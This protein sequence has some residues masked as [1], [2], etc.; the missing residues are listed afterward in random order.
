MC[1][2]TNLVFSIRRRGRG[3]APW[4]APSRPSSELIRSRLS[5]REIMSSSRNLTDLCR[6]CGPVVCCVVTD[7][8]E[9]ISRKNN[10]SFCELLSAFSGAAT[11]AG[12]VPFRSVSGHVTL[13]DL[14]VSFVRASEQSPR[15]LDVGERHIHAAVSH[16]PGEVDVASLIEG[17]AGRGSAPALDGPSAPWY[18]R[19][20][21]ALHASLRC[22]EYDSFDCPALLMLVAATSE[23]VGDLLA[24]FEELH[25]RRHLPTGYHNG[26]FDVSATTK[27]LVLLHDAH[28]GRVRGSE[29]P[30]AQLQRLSAT[31]RTTVCRLLSLNSISPDTPNTE[32]PDIWRDA[33]ELFPGRSRVFAGHADD[34][35]TPSLMPVF[36][37][38]KATW[39]A[40]APVHATRGCCLSPDDVLALRTFVLDVIQQG[41]VPA[42]ETRI[43]AL[44]HAVTSARK[45]VKNVIKG[46]FRR[47]KADGG[48]DAGSAQQAAH[49]LSSATTALYRHDSIEAQ[50]RLLADSAFAM[51]DYEAAL[52]MYKLVRDDYKSDRA[53]AHLGWTCAIIGV[54]LVA[55]DHQRASGGLG[56]GAAAAA[57]H[58]PPDRRALSREADSA[59]DMA[60]HA[61]AAA[62]SHTSAS[63]GDRKE[64]RPQ[65]SL[66]ARM[67]THAM[68]L[69]ADVRA[70]DVGGARHDHAA[71]TLVWAATHETALCAAVL[72]QQ[73]AFHF[74][75]AGLRRKF[76][77]HAAMAGHRFH[78]SNEELHA[79]HCY[80]AVLGLFQEQRRERGDTAP[81]DATGGWAH[82]EDHIAYTLAR[83]LYT[84]KRPEAALQFS[85]RLIASGRQSAD[86]QNTF[87]REFLFICRTQPDA[88][89]S[90]VAQLRGHRAPPSVD[91]PYD[92]GAGA[93]EQ[94]AADSEE[95]RM[96][97]VPELAL[98]RFNDTALALLAWENAAPDGAQ[99]PR[100]T[101]CTVW[102]SQEL[103][104]NAERAVTTR[105]SDG[106]PVSVS[107]RT[108]AGSLASARDDAAMPLR[109]KAAEP[110]PHWAARGEPIV[111]ELELENPLAVVIEV[112]ELQLVAEMDASQVLPAE[113]TCF[114]RPYVCLT[115]FALSGVRRQ[116]TPIHHL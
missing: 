104:L 48:D 69:A 37:A 93:L 17:S 47:P 15:P 72:H 14:H 8:V 35:T 88:I 54:C 23:P 95:Q 49:S 26:Q 109:G 58:A 86:R 87:L 9:R 77:L 57:G 34:D 89:R 110:K 29:P 102:M 18:R 20:R 79:V 11:D 51:R 65:V 39:R 6:S 75:S 103:A 24:S 19:C 108:V 78:A 112:T 116:R 105:T 92:G 84:L 67:V 98:P 107:P 96:I 38:E 2:I 113:S 7:E 25:S 13:D 106:T 43:S 101:D 10:L 3:H 73:A 71:E 5:T 4:A 52:A 1:Y 90:A 70:T 115:T 100:E 81:G 50:I 28:E 41:V 16:G 91:A 32:Q 56:G 76:A 74:R 62:L 36:F 68:L 31:F 27:W 46:F 64:P 33:A 66:V 12:T 45:G 53:W 30:Q 60:Y 80:T 85:L 83:Q 94:V 61:F 21:E 114:R 44:N 59:L 99:S 63:P 82:I 97:E 42:M 55:L 22:S 40:H 111:V